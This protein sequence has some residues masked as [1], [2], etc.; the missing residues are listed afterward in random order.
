MKIDEES[1]VEENSLVSKSNRVAT[2]R[3][4]KYVSFEPQKFTGDSEYQLTVIH[5]YWVF[6]SWWESYISVFFVSGILVFLYYLDI[7]NSKAEN[8][9]W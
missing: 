2:E 4:S 8:Q 9:K 1:G 5:E 6:D 3:G 7:F